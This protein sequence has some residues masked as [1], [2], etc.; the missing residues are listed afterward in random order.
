MWV[1]ALWIHGGSGH[2]LLIAWTVTVFHRPVCGRLGPVWYEWVV[3]P[4]RGGVRWGVLGSL[5]VFP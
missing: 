3:E 4:L 1:A 2:V 5:G